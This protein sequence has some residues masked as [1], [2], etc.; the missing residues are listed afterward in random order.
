MAVSFNNPRSEKPA[1]RSRTA[2]ERFVAPFIIRKGQVEQAFRQLTVLL[3]GDIPVASALETC[4]ELSG[5]DLKDALCEVSDSVR[6]GSALANGLRRSMPWLGELFIGLV[7]AGEANGSLARMFEYG[8]DIMKRRRLVRS[9][10]VRAMTYPAIVVFMGLGVGY[11]VSTVAIPKIVS[12]MGDAETL[13][14][15]TRSLT[16]VSRCLG[17]NGV[18]LLFAPVVAI[19]VC[20]S[21]KRL[22]VVNVVV[23]RVS[24]S[25][26]VFGKVG[27]FSA[28]GLFNYTMGMLVSSG[29]SAVEA[30]NLT[31]TTLSN[32]WYRRQIDSVRRMVMEG[33]MLSDAMRATDLKRLA[34]LVPALIKVGEGTGRMDEGFMYAGDYYS[35][36][37][38]RRLEL[39]GKL[40]EP[41]LIVI[42]GGMVAYVYI[43]FFMGMA[44]MSA[45]AR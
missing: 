38:E 4:A 23:D 40:V 45:A 31:E 1:R 27:R 13:P 11:Y 7:D 18:W 10:V 29:I 16:A 33:K 43:A 30:L 22:P 3:K 9:Q 26:P 2:F 36:A 28:N 24:L 6:R 44:A 25:L 39:L 12:V 14:P 15:I 32:R 19:L 37:L 41:A 20:W 21:L 17:E 42:V 8:A 34:P 35:E 5:S